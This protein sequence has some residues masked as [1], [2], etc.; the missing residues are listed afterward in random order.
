MYNSVIVY[1]VSTPVAVDSS[2]TTASSSALWC[3]FSPSANLVNGA[4]VIV[5]DVH[6]RLSD[7]VLIMYRAGSM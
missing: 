6:A 2:H 4:R 7:T 5:N 1:F 3:R